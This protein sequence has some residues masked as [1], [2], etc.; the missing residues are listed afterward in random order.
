MLCF[1]SPKFFES[2]EGI[3]ITVLAAGQGDSSI[4]EFPDGRVM[5]IDGG[6]KEEY[7]LKVLKR[8]KIKKINVLALSHP[9]ADHIM[10]FFR[11]LEEIEVLEIWH[12]GF[13]RRNFLMSKLLDLASQK[14]IKIKTVRELHGKHDFGDSSVTILA[15]QKFDPQSSTNN[16]SLV[17]KVA[18]G[19]DSALWPGDLE[20]EKE[21][22]ATVDWKATVLKAPHHGSKSSSSR[23]LVKMVAPEHVIFCTQAENKFG[24]PYP[25][26]KERWEASHAK[27]WDTG[28]KGEL[29]LTLTGSGVLVRSYL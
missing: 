7:L 6:P 15:P 27:T 16:N 14:K 13:D 25:A 19:Q 28:I 23:H 10:G 12:S 22:Q 3:Q 24:F 8:Q 18:L 20:S 26:V 17:I 11:V 9:D 5:V 2:P 21:S 4:F 1:L 29:R